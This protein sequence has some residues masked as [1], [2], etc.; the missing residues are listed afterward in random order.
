MMTG[1]KTDIENLNTRMAHVNTNHLET[2]KR[3]ALMGTST[4]NTETK[5][6]NMETKIANFQ[7]NLEAKFDAVNDEVRDIKSTLTE[8][9]RGLELLKEEVL[10]KIEGEERMQEDSTGN[11]SATASG[12]CE[13]QHIFVA[14]GAGSNSVEI[15]NYRQRRWW[16]LKPMPARRDSATSFV[17]NNYVTVAGGGKGHDVI[18]NMIQMN[19]HPIPDLSINWSDFPAK[20]PA[21]MYAHS[22]VV[23]KDSLFITGG[24][25]EDRKVFS[26]CIYEVELKPPYTVKM[27]AR[28]PEPRAYHSAVLCDDDILIF[29][30]SKT[31]DCPDNLSSVLS[32]DIKMN[33]CR[34]LPALPFAVSEMATVKWAEN[35]V[36]IG[37]A[38]KDGKALN[39]VIFYNT[40]TGNSHMLP[41]M[42]H[43]RHGCTAVVIK[44][45]IVVFGGCD[46][47]FLK[48]VEG[49]SFESYSWREFPEMKNPRYLATAAVI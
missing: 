49:F 30:G 8:V 17:Y 40:K 37:G 23:Y 26:K 35:V 6:E 12:G 10:E 43:K 29:G 45:T 7:E 48:S 22:S 11:A 36:I 13:Q 44:D 2:I 27:V 47:M 19:V 28:M 5:L 4:L 15:F 42:L 25:N 24:Y 9:K 33:K 3:L 34:Q 31:E 14:G 21:K 46:E 16:L 18:D 41:P 38:D 39:N 1:M 32:Y 20:L